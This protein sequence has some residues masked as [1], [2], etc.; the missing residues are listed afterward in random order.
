MVFMVITVLSIL[1]ASL[2]SRTISGTKFSRIFDASSRSLWLAEA[3]VQK[4]MWSMNNGN[5]TGWDGTTEKRLES[6]IEN[7]GDFEVTV[8]DYQGSAPILTATGFY[9]SR[10]A[11]EAVSRTVQVKARRYGS[12]FNYAAFGETDLDLSGNGK[13]DSYN[14]T[15]GAYGG[16]NVGEDGDIG[17][18]GDISLNG[19]NVL[20]AG[21]ASTGTNGTFEDTTDQVTGT[22]SHADA[23]ALTSVTVPSNLLTLTNEGE[24]DDDMTIQ[25][26]HTFTSIDLSSSETL[27][28]NG[29]SNIYLTGSKS[30]SLSSSAKIQ[31]TGNSTVNFYVDGDVDASAG[32]I[33]NTASL[34]E[35]LFIYGTSTC[36]DIKFTADSSFY[37][38]VY[39]PDALLQLTGKGALY[40]SFIGN[41]VKISGQ[42]GVHY[43]SA[44][45]DIDNGYGKYRIQAWKEANNPFALEE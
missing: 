16:S 15:L 31:I 24:I 44:L 39:A 38:A 13:T 7:G 25:G 19:E 42:G 32:G 26:N 40:G 34:P 41:D 6:E 18:N 8:N 28:I 5:W 30:I 1:S 17:T 10:E 11:T 23:S 14:S 45:K 3:G 20:V 4:A 35:K 12:P 22:V 29:T 43:D 9:P 37:G 33:I 27:V 2:V 36:T 21:D